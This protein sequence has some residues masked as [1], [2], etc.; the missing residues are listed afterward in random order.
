MLWLRRLADKGQEPGLGET[1]EAVQILSV[2]RSKGLE[3]PTVFVVGM[4][5]DIFPSITSQNQGKEEE[6]RRLAYVAI[7]RA[8]K[9]LFLSHVEERVRFGQREDM[10]RSRFLDEI[11][12][13]LLTEREAEEDSYQPSL[14]GSFSG[15][16]SRYR[17]NQSHSLYSFGSEKGASGFSGTSR[18]HSSSK[19]ETPEF[20]VGSK[21]RHKLMGLG[22]VEK[23]LST[24]TGNKIR[25][26]FR[27][28]GSISLSVFDKSLELW[29]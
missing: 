2:H 11:P 6:E 19:S 22:T 9:N 8:Q 13:E 7:T 26:N 28:Y 10:K 5:E 3:F 18:S 16:S 14:F 12:P 21:V 25:V 20:K 4:D 23:V 1:G 27:A 15:G 17:S 24:P 29:D